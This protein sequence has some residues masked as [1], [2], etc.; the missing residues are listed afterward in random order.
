MSL[1]KRIRNKGVILAMPCEYV[2]NVGQIKD[3]KE[4][5]PDLW[6]LI[7][8]CFEFG[9]MQGIRAERAGKAKDFQ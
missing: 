9:Y 3:L 4:N 5:A 7:T 8:V 1:Y 6:E 2:P